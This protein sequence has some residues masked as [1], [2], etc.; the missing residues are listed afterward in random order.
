MLKLAQR[1]YSKMLMLV[2]QLVSKAGGS[3]EDQDNQIGE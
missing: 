2:G 3:H 1:H